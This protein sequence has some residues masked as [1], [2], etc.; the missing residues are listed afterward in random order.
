MTTGAIIF[1]DVFTTI[2][3]LKDSKCVYNNVEEVGE[4]DVLK[5]IA[6]YRHNQS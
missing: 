4:R 2:T 5:L 1:F 3:S 6:N